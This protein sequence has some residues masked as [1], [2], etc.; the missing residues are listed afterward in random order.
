MSRR[1]AAGGTTCCPANSLQVE[2]VEFKLI[3]QTTASDNTLLTNHHELQEKRL[4]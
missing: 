2:V 1:C 4:Q 3:A